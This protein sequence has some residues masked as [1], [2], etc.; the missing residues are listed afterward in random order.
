[1][2]A[3]LESR[4]ARCDASSVGYRF[5]SI[6]AHRL[7]GAQS[8]EGVEELLEPD[9]PELRNILDR[10]L[11]GAEFR[12]SRARDKL[13]ALLHG[14]VEP[15]YGSPGRGC[16]RT[17]IFAQPPQDLPALLRMADHLDRLARQDAGERALVWRCTQCQ[18]RYAVP[19]ALVRDVAIRCERC[20]DTVDLSPN[21]SMGEEALL[22]PFQSE[23][24]AVRGRLATFFREAMARGWPVLVCTTD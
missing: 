20:G 5:F 22:D 19:V 14:D 2:H 21:R 8:L 24:N 3:E 9:A 17:A 16:G 13:R 12:D 15:P 23:V 4:A 10:A 7:T 18:T 6:P 11:Q 1:M